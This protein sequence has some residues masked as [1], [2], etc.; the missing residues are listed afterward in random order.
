MYTYKTTGNGLTVEIFNPSGD[1]V[2]FLQGDDAAELIDQI[3]DIRGMWFFGKPTQGNMTLDE[4]VFANEEEHI[5]ALL[6]AYDMEG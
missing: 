2:A 6:D 5:S 3:E 1:S 4:F